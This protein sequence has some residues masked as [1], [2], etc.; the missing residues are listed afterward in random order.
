MN[1]RGRGS[2]SDRGGRGRGKKPEILAQVGNKTLVNMR[3]D[4]EYQKYLEFSRQNSTASTN[5]VPTYADIVATE[6]SE[7][8]HTAYLM[9]RRQEV[10]LLLKER[11][12][13]WSEDPWILMRKYMDTKAFPS[14][15]YKGRMFYENIL[16]ETGCEISHT[17]NKVQPEIYD[18]SKITIKRIISLQ[19]WG[20]SPISTRE[21]FFGQNKTPCKY[22]FWDYM[23]AFDRAPLYENPKHKHSW[24]VRICP[25]AYKSDIPAWFILWWQHFGT[26]EEILPKD[27]KDRFWNWD[28]IFRMNADT[29]QINGYDTICE[30]DE[31]IMFYEE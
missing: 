24:F 23:D 20:M 5:E 28:K 21:F 29:K 31:K 26:T 6:E 11:D 25:V 13:R 27:F 16:K 12:Y 10:I 3:Q 17:M 4:K 8:G 14:K 1:S 9:N 15:T 18:Y 30:I 22:N 2:S 19:D 7:T